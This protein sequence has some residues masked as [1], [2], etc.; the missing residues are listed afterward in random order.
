MLSR[1]EQTQDIGQLATGLLV[2]DR[3]PPPQ[4]ISKIVEGSDYAVKILQGSGYTLHSS[5][6]GLLFPQR[7]Y[8]TKEE[9]ENTRVVLSTADG[10][11]GYLPNIPN[12]EV[13]S[14]IKGFEGAN[15]GGITRRLKFVGY[16]LLLGGAGY[17]AVM[18]P[19][20]NNTSSY[21][22]VAYI[23]FI[24][25]PI[26][27]SALFLHEAWLHF[28][29]KGFKRYEPKLMWGKQALEKASS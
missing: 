23:S 14:F 9:G 20:K 19:F 28:H 10:H 8:F 24:A 6:G 2:Q 25:F 5:E 13:N 18:D 22:T 3:I 12:G 1:M 17:F 27:V 16:S 29:N 21:D 15:F 26:F 4:N 11:F 7:N